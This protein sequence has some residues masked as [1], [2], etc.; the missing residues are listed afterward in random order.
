MNC[1]AIEF[2]KHKLIG[3]TS[4]KRCCFTGQSRYKFSPDSNVHPRLVACLQLASINQKA[5]PFISRAT[6]RRG[7]S[8]QA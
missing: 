7:R 1:P 4:M 5:S 3:Q 2:E 8:K 6:N